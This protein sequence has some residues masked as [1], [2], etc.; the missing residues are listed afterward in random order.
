M[1]LKPAAT[2][3]IANSFSIAKSPYQGDT[4]TRQFQ[5]DYD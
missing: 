3:S 1:S 4:L 5:V 2:F